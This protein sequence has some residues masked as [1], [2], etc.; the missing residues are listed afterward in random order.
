MVQALLVVAALAGRAAE[1]E[2]EVHTIPGPG[3]LLP[4]KIAAAK[5][6]AGDVAGV[7]LYYSRDRGRTWEFHEEIAPGK[8]HFAFSAP[9]PGEYWFTARLKMKDGTFNPPGVANL[10]PMQKARILSGT[11]PTEKPPAADVARE[12]AD[13][14][15]RVELELIRGEIKRLA[16]AKELTAEVEEKIDRLRK[17]L[18]GL[19]ERTGAGRLVPPALFPDPLPT[20]PPAAP[21][22]SRIPPP[23][24]IPAT[25]SA[26]PMPRARGRSS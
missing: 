9:R 21:E 8:P 5:D 6:A 11:E 12:L 17:R 25:R 23:A 19:R 2:L 14:L 18:G 16:E 15:T 20:L 24:I 7:Q 1:P 3:L 4:C 26:A 22:E 10:V 13:E